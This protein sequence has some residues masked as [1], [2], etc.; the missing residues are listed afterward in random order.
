MIERIKPSDPVEGSAYRY[1]HTLPINL[2]EAW[3]S[4]TTPSP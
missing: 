2:D 3:T 4:S 1:A